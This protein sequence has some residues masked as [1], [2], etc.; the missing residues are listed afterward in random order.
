MHLVL[1]EQRGVVPVVLAARCVVALAV[2]VGQ[3]VVVVVVPVAQPAFELAAARLLVSV[4]VAQAVA[5]DGARLGCPSLLRQPARLPV[6]CAR[7]L[8]AGLADQ[9]F[10]HFDEQA[11]ERSRSDARL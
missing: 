3:Y 2:I 10:D 8:P 1:A 6:V 11:L 5:T 4:V 9:H 7:R